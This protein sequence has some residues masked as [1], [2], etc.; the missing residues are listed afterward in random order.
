MS[1]L[2]S[3]HLAFAAFW[4]H[5]LVVWARMATFI[6]LLL[7]NWD[8]LVAGG[9]KGALIGGAFTMAPLMLFL[10]WTAWRGDRAGRV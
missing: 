7:S 5:P 9:W 10:A 3:L 2:N 6:A 4:E 8:Y 1:V